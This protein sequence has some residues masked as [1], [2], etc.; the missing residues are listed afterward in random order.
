MFP[1]KSKDFV[2]NIGEDDIALVKEV[3]KNLNEYS[4]SK[5]LKLK[6]TN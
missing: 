6:R 5:Q 2:V 1:D 4:I 3:K